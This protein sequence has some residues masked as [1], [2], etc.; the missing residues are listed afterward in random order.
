VVSEANNIKLER[1]M[2]EVIPWVLPLIAVL[3]LI[4]YFPALVL[5]VP[6]W[7]MPGR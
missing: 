1:L 7:L 5:L 4:T 6:N 3:F 2:R